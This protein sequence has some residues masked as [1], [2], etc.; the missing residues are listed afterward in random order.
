MGDLNYILCF[1]LPKEI[2][3]RIFC[4]YLSIQDISHL[5]IAIC[6]HRNRPSFLECVG[7]VA[8]VWPGDK[9]RPLG[10][11]EICWMSARNIKV[12]LLNCDAVNDD[13]AFRI[14]NCGIYLEWLIIDRQYFYDIGMIK[15][16][17]NCPNLKHLSISR[18]NNITD[19]SLIKIAE[20]CPDIN[21][22]NIAECRVTDEVWYVYMYTSIY[23]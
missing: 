21:Y 1:S 2:L 3:S 12:R 13:T 11:K 20:C 19:I 7:S 5:D 10:F 15:I 22:L 4:K 14:A 17:E 9:E 8:C 16:T 18:C 23:M 6:N